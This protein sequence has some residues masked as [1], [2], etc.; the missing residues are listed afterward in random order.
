MTRCIGEIVEE[1]CDGGP[2][3]ADVVEQVL[4]FG[5]YEKP[6][7]EWLEAYR[8]HRNMLIRVLSQFGIYHPAIDPIVALETMASDWIIEEDTSR[9]SIQK[10]VWELLLT[11]DLCMVLERKLNIAPERQAAA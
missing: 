4:R 9:G 3:P 7:K 8:S 6:S 5:R 11:D 10:R 1:I 2:Y